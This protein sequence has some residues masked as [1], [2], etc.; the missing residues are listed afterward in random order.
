MKYSE[1]KGLVLENIVAIELFRRGEE[2][3]Y[4]QDKG[5]CDFVLKD[6]MGFEIK[7]AIQVT[8]ELNFHTQERELAGILQVL[9]RSSLKE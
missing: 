6:K 1:N 3:Y 7:Q 8:W 5:E 4:F 2:F 9:E